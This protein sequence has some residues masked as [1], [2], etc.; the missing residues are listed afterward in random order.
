MILN[1]PNLITLL[2]ILVTPLF[3]IFMIRGQYHLALLVFTLA[4]YLIHDVHKDLPF[5][6]L[7]SLEAIDPGSDRCP[8]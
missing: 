2:R 7:Y 4:G 8:R 5:M 6:L 3:V 1:V